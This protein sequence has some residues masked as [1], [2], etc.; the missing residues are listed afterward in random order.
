M[1]LPSLRTHQRGE[2]LHMVR[3]SDWA[4][5]PVKGGSSFAVFFSSTTIVADCNCFAA[6]EFG[7]LALVWGV[8]WR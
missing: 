6:A 7:E 5:E 8:S 2:R 3:R 1:S 4:V